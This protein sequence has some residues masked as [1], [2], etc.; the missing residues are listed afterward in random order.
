MIK[1]ETFICKCHSLE[2]QYSFWYDEEDNELY[3]EPHLFNHGTWYTRLV[4]RIK[5]LI[6]Y[7]SPYGAFDSVLI[8][9]EDVDKLIDV[10]KKV[11]KSDINLIADRGRD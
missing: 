11:K 3:F 9:N 8:N 2:H 4:N 5:Y 7:D 1:R 10:L 6:G